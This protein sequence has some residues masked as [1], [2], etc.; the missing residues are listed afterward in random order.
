MG[1]GCYVSE[2]GGTRNK[3]GNPPIGKKRPLPVPAV[4]MLITSMGV[5][6][7]ARP[8]SQPDLLVNDHLLTHPLST[9]LVRS[10]PTQV[11][12]RL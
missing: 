6:L 11:Y 1:I 9:A 3:A 2:V 8:A 7:N 12:T 4:A 10:K 5:R